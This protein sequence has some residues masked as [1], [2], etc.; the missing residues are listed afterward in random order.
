MNITGVFIRRPVATTL[1]AIATVLSGLLAFFK[2]PVAP[3][4]NI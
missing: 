1:L 4:P 2:L 3:L